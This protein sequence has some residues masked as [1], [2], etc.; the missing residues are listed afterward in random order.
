MICERAIEESL[1]GLH[2]KFYLENLLWFPTS[3]SEAKLTQMA[4]PVAELY[5]RLS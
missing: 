4:E 5:F 2:R 1:S 3:G